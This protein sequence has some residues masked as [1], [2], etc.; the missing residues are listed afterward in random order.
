MNPRLLCAVI[1]VAFLASVPP[2][3]PASPQS[4]PEPVCNSCHEQAQK[5]PKSAH[6]SLGC[7]N[8]HL[9]HEDYP[10]PASLPKPACIECHATQVGEHEQSVHGQ[11]LEHG[12][13]AAPDCSVCHGDVHEL[14][15]TRSAAFRQTV[16]DTCGTCH[17][18]IA[19]QFGSSVHGRAVAA[20]IAEAP[21]CTSCHGEHLILAPTNVRSAVNPAHVRETCGECHG[22][23]RLASRFGLPADR[24]LS[25]DASFHGMAAKAGSQSVANCASCHGVHNIL[26]SSDPRSTVHPKNLAATCGK[27]HPG[28]GSRFALGLVHQ[29]PGGAEPRPVRWARAFYLAVIPLTIGLMFLHNLGDWV[30]KLVERRFGRP[31]ERRASPALSP[32]PAT[33]EIRMYGWERLQHAL[34]LVSFAALVWTGF[35]LHYPDGWWAR[36]VVAWESRGLVRGSIHRLAAAIFLA[37]A[38]L[39]VLSLVTSPRLRRHWKALWPRRDDLGAALGN[40]A[41]NLGLRST[42]PSLAEHSYVEKV[43]Y[44]AVVWGALIMAVTGILLWANTFF[45][46]WLPKLILDLATTVHF[47]EAVLAALAILVWHL[48]SAIFD[49]DVYPMETAWLTGRSVKRREAAQ[50]GQSTAANR[51]EKKTDSA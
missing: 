17:S 13:A 24:V 3:L 51:D 4:S 15:A 12:N 28:A 14:V 34:L 19:A 21:V 22:N 39:H 8:C 50:A 49:P 33:E 35:A 7:T 5:L 37:V 38:G 45:L 36:P 18:E 26:P 31:P 30:R 1:G 40:F 41:F 43:E 23:V 6:A 29:L 46:A 48:Y 47:Y 32:P 20:G 42:R 44:W 25:F 9:R 11:A 16:P 10:H 27:C 2:T